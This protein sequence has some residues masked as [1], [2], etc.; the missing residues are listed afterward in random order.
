MNRPAK[1]ITSCALFEA[2]GRAGL[3]KRVARLECDAGEWGHPD[4]RPGSG[5]E[6]SGS[7]VCDRLDLPP[8]PCV[9]VSVGI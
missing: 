3:S 6:D 5:F 7:P 9:W 4:R 8:D 2:R 1:R